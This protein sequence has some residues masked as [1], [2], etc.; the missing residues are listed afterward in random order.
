MHR[1][2]ETIRF[3]KGCFHNLPYHNQRMNLTRGHFF[4]RHDSLFLENYL[5]PLAAHAAFPHAATASADGTFACSPAPCRIKCRVE[6]ADDILTIDYTP[7]HLRP[8]RT[9]RLTP[10]DT[11]D[12]TYKSTNRTYLQTLF[13]NRNGADDI[14]LTR[15]GYLTDTSICNIAL[16]DGHT[17]Y[18]PLHPLLAGTQRQALL[19]AGVLV[20]RPI[21]ASTLSY[22]TH[23]RLFNALIPFGELHLPV[24]A[25][26]PSPN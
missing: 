5:D 14:L 16:Y 13:E 21:P 9:L 11:F 12:Y 3:E 8:V 24:T 23:L 7:Y 25:I 26:L 18:T 10:A 4:G 6:Y 22:Y 20:A 17:W 1:F 15:H 19:D 2:I